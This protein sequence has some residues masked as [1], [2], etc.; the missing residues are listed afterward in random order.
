MYFHR[1][2]NI[3]KAR[4]VWQTMSSRARARAQP[5]GR[6][7]PGSRGG[8]DFFQCCGVHRGDPKTIATTVQEAVGLAFS[9]YVKWGPRQLERLTSSTAMPK[10][11]KPAG[12]LEPQ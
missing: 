12:G 3:K 4:K 7:K 10:T 5:S 2:R 8:G 6:A 11:N 9:R 1:R